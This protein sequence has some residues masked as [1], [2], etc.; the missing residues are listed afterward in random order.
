MKNDE[1]IKPKSGSLRIQSHSD[2]GDERNAPRRVKTTRDT[3]QH[4]PRAQEGSENF[5][6]L[7]ANAM[8]G[9]HSTKPFPGDL[10]V[11]PFLS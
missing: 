4:E 10:P 3:K 11:Q 1:V 8:H 2:P 9:G 6:F 5:S 7:L